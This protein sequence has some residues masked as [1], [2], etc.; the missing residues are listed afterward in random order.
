[1]RDRAIGSRGKEA[2]LAK[3]QVLTRA[4]GGTLALALPAGLLALGILAALD[5]YLPRIAS[6]LPGADWNALALEA[7]ARWPEAAGIL[8]GQLLLLAI[9]LIGGRKALDRRAQA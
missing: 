7:S 9:L 6:W 2:D 4:V 8:V 3:L 5:E 1:L